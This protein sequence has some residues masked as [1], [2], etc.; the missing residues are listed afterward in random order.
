MTSLILREY[1]VIFMA[2]MVGLTREAKAKAI[3]HL[4]KHMAPGALLMLRSSHGLRSFIYQSVDPSD[5]KGF[6]VLTI[7]HPMT[8][9]VPTSVVIARKL[10]GKST[11]EEKNGIRSGKI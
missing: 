9:D 2:S 3:E 8:N 4:E 11:Y 10:G 1:D 5:L 7:H 6:D